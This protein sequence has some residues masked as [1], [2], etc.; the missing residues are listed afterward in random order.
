MLRQLALSIGL[1]ASFS[2]VPWLSA[3]NAE[4]IAAA[5]GAQESPR[6]Q[7]Y[8][9]PRIAQDSGLVCRMDCAQNFRFCIAECTT[10][11]T[12]QCAPQCGAH[13]SACWRG[14]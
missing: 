2:T 8:R 5:V 6:A 11:A 7:S 12:N 3:A 1:V 9:P 10:G 13:Q 4:G 14:C